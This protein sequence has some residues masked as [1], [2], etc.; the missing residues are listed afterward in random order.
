[1]IP[2]GNA[3]AF[4]DRFTGELSQFLRDA[5][6][7]DTARFPLSG[8]QSLILERQ[9]RP[10][11]H[12]AFARFNVQ[13]LLELTGPLEKDR[14]TR[15]LRALVARHPALQT[16]FHLDDRRFSQSFVNQASTLQVIDLNGREKQELGRLIE[17][18]KATRSVLVGG[19]L[20]HFFL[21]N[22]SEQAHVLQIVL[23]H[24]IT[25]GKSTGILRRDLLRYYEEDAD[26]TPVPDPVY[27]GFLHWSQ[28][29]EGSRMFVDAGRLWTS[30]LLSARAD[31]VAFPEQP[32]SERPKRA[33]T[34]THYRFALDGLEIS[35][36][37][38]TALALRV[39]PA[40]IIIAAVLMLSAG[41]AAFCSPACPEAILVEEGR[42]FKELQQTCGW[43][44]QS[45]PIVAPMSP[46]DGA[47]AFI[48]SVHQ[49]ITRGR[50]LP[51][52]QRAVGQLFPSD[53]AGP[54]GRGKIAF[55]LLPA[56]GPPTQAG[57]ICARRLETT[58][59]VELEFDLVLSLRVYDAAF[60]LEWWVNSSV[61]K[62]EDVA[63]LNQR[64]VALVHRLI[65]APACPIGEL[66]VSTAAMNDLLYVG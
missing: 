39:T 26:D 10:G 49:Q 53:H 13:I 32:R 54:F 5:D 41:P 17:R 25:D 23:N 45:V 21:Y 60:D 44:A 46:A 22:I 20:H 50:A 34:D 43:F 37:R 33:L 48:K 18:N 1:M 56:M 11:D 9:D 24:L 61:F 6:D 14:L 19:V 47:S 51:M 42:W 2:N 65:A 7:W 3:D 35:A 16:R 62:Q 12:R 27:P 4:Q 31:H 55:N 59:N 8:V 29:E 57:P 66:L 15:A 30:F 38:R 52:Q 40:A 28:S 58:A 36:A 64:T 63:K